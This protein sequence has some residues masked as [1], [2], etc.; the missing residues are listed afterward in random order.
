M[1]DNVAKEERKVA[2]WNHVIKAY[3][4]DVYSPRR[5]RMVPNLTDEHVY[6]NKIKKM[7]VKLMMQV[8]SEKLSNFIDLLSRSPGN[9]YP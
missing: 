3:L 2:D 4:I 7:C 6:P 5:N 9:F 8:F 1:E